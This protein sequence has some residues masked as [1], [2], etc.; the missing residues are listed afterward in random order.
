M[1]LSLTVSL[2]R[3]LAGLV[4]ALLVVVHL[5]GLARLGGCCVVGDGGKGRRRER[6]RAKKK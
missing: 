5:V 4:G 6:E 3:T 1:P 2:S